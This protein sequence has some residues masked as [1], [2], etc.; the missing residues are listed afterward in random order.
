MKKKNEKRLVNV[1]ATIIVAI[2]VTAALLLAVW[3]VC[4]GFGIKFNAKYALP[5]FAF[6]F[7]NKLF[8]IN[9]YHNFKKER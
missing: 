2:S 4:I 3:L 1:L 6:I 9:L 7:L 5:I 8:P